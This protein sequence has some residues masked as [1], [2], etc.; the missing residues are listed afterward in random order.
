MVAVPHVDSTGGVR[1][2]YH[3]LGGTGANLLLSHATGFHAYVWAPM[4]AALA[5]RYHSV[6][7]DYRGHGD[8]TPPTDGAFDWIGFRDDTITVLDELAW[9]RP[10]AAGHSMGGAAL[11]MTELARPGTFR[12]LALFEPIVV[13]PDWRSD[14]ENPLVGGAR[15]RRSSFGS[16]QDALDHFAA[17][18]PLD[19]LDPAALAAYVDHGFLLQPDGSVTLKCLGEH[20]ARVYEMSASQ[21][22]YERLPEI[23]CPVLVMGGPPDD[24]GPGRFAPTVAGQLGRGHYELV[25]GVGHFGPL[26]D[27]GLL[28]EL[29]DGFF[30]ASG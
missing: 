12:A 30:T 8:S 1:I 23:Q 7:I 5:A 6:A 3:D 15:R 10:F 16:H 27:P 29:I 26:E 21:P 25:T 9:H 22:I 20:E 11:L 14:G 13:T 18:P 19:V 24:L 17:K 4:A 2:A 28:A